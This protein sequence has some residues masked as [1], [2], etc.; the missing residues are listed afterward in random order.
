MIPKTGNRF[1]DKIMRK[2]LSSRRERL[3]RRAD[4][5]AAA[6]GHAQHREAAL[7][8]AVAVESEYAVDAG[9]TRR[10]CQHLLTE[11]LRT[12]RLHQRR[13]QRDRVISKRRRAHRFLIVAGAVAAR[14]TT[15]AGR[16]RR[17]IP[18]AIERRRGEDTR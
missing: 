5:L 7:I 10:G 3:R 16:L 11:A 8:C 12:L 2:K 4:R 13:H 15:E 6:R 9:E 14:E 1:S 17:R 18:T